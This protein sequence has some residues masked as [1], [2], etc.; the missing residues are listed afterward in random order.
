LDGHSPNLDDALELLGSPERR[1]ILDH[2]V[3][4]SIETMAA[5]ELASG[6]AAS[7]TDG[8]SVES[9]EKEALAV[10]LHHSHLPKLIIT[11]FWSTTR[12]RTPFVVV[13]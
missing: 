12:G 3:D 4:E 5:T 2:L 13:R 11:A 1:R 9:G 7:T 6:L 10:R 8:P